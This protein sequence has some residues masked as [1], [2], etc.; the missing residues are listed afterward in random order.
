MTWWRIL[1]DIGALIL[2]LLT[3]WW[4]VFLYILIGVVL[5]PWYIEAVFWGLFFDVMYG[6]PL[7]SWYVRIM[8]TALFTLP[9]LL[10]TFIKQRINV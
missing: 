6:T 5:F 7:V 1:F 2:V 10:S 8:H 9:V 4:V 3:P